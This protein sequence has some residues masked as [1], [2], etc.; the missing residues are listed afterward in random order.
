MHS[1]E[2]GRLSYPVRARGWLS[3]LR[4]VTEMPVRRTD[5][6]GL[7]RY[8][9]LSLYKDG[10]RAASSGLA[11]LEIGTH[12]LDRSPNLD[13]ERTG[14]VQRL[15]VVVSTRHNSYCEPSLNFFKYPGQYCVCVAAIFLPQVLRLQTSANHLACL[16]SF[17]KKHKSNRV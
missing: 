12:L 14:L 13:A 16:Y 5:R 4:Q 6:I 1:L 9:Q 3:K 15:A 10:H 17:F 8:S 7:I 11:L 2:L